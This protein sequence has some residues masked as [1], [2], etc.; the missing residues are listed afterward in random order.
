MG[1][2][3]VKVICNFAMLF[4][5]DAMGLAIGPSQ[6]TMETKGGCALL[7][8]AILMALEA[9]PNLVAVCLDNINAYGDIERECIDAAIRA[10]PYRHPFLPLFELLYKKR[11]R[12]LW[13]YDD[14][15]NFIL[16][17]RNKREVRQGCVL[18]MFLFYLTI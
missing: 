14:D 11:A 10:N 17:T 3:I 2:A 8:W 13:Y 15:G 5:K 12:D 9:K 4:V 16:G 1:M 18:G 7:Q 6:F